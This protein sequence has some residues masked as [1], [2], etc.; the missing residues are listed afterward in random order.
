MTG[1]LKIAAAQIDTTVG[2]LAGNAQ[3][4]MA[5][6]RKAEVEG[7]DLV[8]TPE[9]SLTGYPLED[10]NENP[11]TLDQALKVA[12]KLVEA[13]KNFKSAVL[14]GLP[15]RGE[16]T[17]EGRSVYNAAL[18]I[19]NGQIRQTIRKRHLPTYDVFDERRTLAPGGASD[20]VDFRGCKL[21]VMIC[22]DFWYEDAAADLAA[23]GAQ[24][25]IVM[26]ASPFE[27]QKHERR[28]TDVAGSRA[29]ETKLPILYVNQTGGQDEIVF[30]GCSFA[31]N[32]DGVVMYQA[33]AFD[34][35]Q[36]TLSLNFAPGAPASFGQAAIH[37]VPADMERVWRA[38]VTG[39]REY[40]RKNGNITDVVLG[41]SGGIDSALVA[42]IAADAIGSAHVHLIS[43]PSKFTADMSNDDAFAA[44]K[45]LGADIFQKPIETAVQTFR[46]LFNGQSAGT[47]DENL[48]SRVRGI[49]L[50]HHSNTHGWLPLTTGNKSEMGVGYCTLYGDTNGGFN[51][52]K[53]VYKEL[54]RELAR[55]RNANW[56]AGLLGPQGPVMPDRIITRPPSAELAAGQKDEDDLPPYPVLDEILHRYIEEDQKLERIIA[57]TGFE[58]AL[59]EKVIRKVDVA[60]FKRRQTCPGVKI[61]EKSF[62]RGRQFP[63]SRPN[64][65]RMIREAEAFKPAP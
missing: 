32:N 17:P 8:V 33:P 64:T 10:Q 38:L 2:D 21:G 54:V 16:K 25:L 31:M 65:P 39:V 7:V 5:A 42:A 57:E 59:V 49:I 51:P 11:D 35:S 62:G 47:A 13:S 26:N 1:T 9:M 45:M 60:E 52:L 23:K 22:E 24:A 44:A 61:T 29:A 34:E 15:L 4:I 6:W 37:P 27:R 63:I 58:R 50:M 28:I 48:Q 36:G 41:M 19:E 43:M 30:D 46:D 12:E 40:L 56:P 53:D 55:W 18:L 3:K 20:P 14:I